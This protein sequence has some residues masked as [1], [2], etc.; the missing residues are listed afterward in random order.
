MQDKKIFIGTLA[1]YIPQQKTFKEVPAD[2]LYR[3]F[4]KNNIP[5]I[6]N[7]HYPNRLQQ[8]VSALWLIIKNRQT[9][10]AAIMPL[11]GT[12]NSIKWY[13][14]IASVLRLY[15]IPL[16][17]VV[18]GGSIPEQLKM[19]PDKIKTLFKNTGTII[20]PSG[21]LKD[22]LKQIN[23]SA[24]VIE[25]PLPLHHYTFIKKE[26]FRPHILWM[27]TFHEIY[28]PL[29]AVDVAAILIKKYPAFKMVMAGADQ[30]M[31]QQTKNLAH[32]HGLQNHIS[33]PG[34][35][36]LS[37]KLQLASE[38]DIYICTN[39]VDNAPSTL[40]ECM[41]MGLPVVSTNAGGI[42]W[43]VKDNHNGLLVNTGDAA[44]MAEKVE[45]LIRHSLATKNI[46][47]N[48]KDYSSQYDENTVLHK[49][50]KILQEIIK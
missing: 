20:S 26:N 31:M 33:F 2:D 32:E 37:Q 4:T 34:F 16:I 38:Y 1:T 5:C 6:I 9:I 3:L 47:H 21:Y 14:V 48:A 15:K 44:A 41:A 17:T 25:N 8:L 27:R 23:I 49:W 24:E 43:I 29:M 42:P 40:V 12:A 13:K 28:N 45:Y 19:Y 7:R 46:I 36:N 50:K 10:H 30:G 39:A 35:I 11:Y 18:R 22:I